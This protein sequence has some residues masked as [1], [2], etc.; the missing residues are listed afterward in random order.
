MKEVF[1]HKAALIDKI[2]KTID[3]TDDSEFSE[4]AQAEKEYIMAIIDIMPEVIIE[5]TKQGRK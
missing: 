1:I 3:S 4:G 5:T 2:K